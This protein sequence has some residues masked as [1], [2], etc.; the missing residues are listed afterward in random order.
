MRDGAL[1]QVAAIFGV[2]V[3]HEYETGDIM[4]RDDFVTAL[5]R[6][7]GAPIKLLLTGSTDFDS[8]ILW[9]PELVGRP[10][11]EYQ[12]APAKT[13]V[14]RLLGSM[15]VNQVYADHVRSVLGYDA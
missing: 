11:F 5:G 4:V 15:Q 2:H 12:Q 1:E 7:L 10:M 14:G 6:R 13:F 8:R 9:P 3:T